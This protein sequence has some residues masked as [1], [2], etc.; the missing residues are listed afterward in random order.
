MIRIAIIEKGRITPPEDLASP[1]Q[2]R[3]AMEQARKLIVECEVRLKSMTPEQ[4]TKPAQRA[5]APYLS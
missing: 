5:A 3:S 1:E 2:L 4:V